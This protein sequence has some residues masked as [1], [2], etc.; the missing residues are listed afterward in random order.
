[1]QATRMTIWGDNLSVE[2]NKNLMYK[3]S[4]WYEEYGFGW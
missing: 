3:T 4:L 2:M 1:M